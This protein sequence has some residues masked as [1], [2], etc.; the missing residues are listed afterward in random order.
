M[1][2]VNWSRLQ[3]E[4]AAS[5]HKHG[6][7][8]TPGPA[9]TNH[10]NKRQSSR[11]RYGATRSVAMTTEVN[12]HGICGG[13]CTASLALAFSS[14]S[15]LLGAQR[16]SADRNWKKRCQRQFLFSEILYWSVGE[17]GSLWSPNLSW[18]LLLNPRGV[19]H[20]ILHFWWASRIKSCC[21]C[22]KSF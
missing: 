18:C 20:W 14:T 5:G 4:E 16:R 10:H 7:P 12:K 6:P 22:K 1:D 19:K 15:R 21:C 3:E 8:R 11:G 9:G 13:V 17:E 2:R